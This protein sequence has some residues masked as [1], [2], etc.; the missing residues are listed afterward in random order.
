LRS[1]SSI[2]FGSPRTAEHEFA[3]D[4][5]DEVH[6]DNDGEVA[7][8]D[9]AS[10]GVRPNAGTVGKTL[11]VGAPTPPGDR[12]EIPRGL[13]HAAARFAHPAGDGL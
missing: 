11:V 1:G 12:T 13:V 7:I 10:H 5:R 4:A 8:T 9:I 3:A 2:H 6:I